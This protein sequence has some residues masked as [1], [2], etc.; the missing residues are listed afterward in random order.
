[1]TV[2]LTFLTR[3]RAEVVRSGAAVER[4][5]RKQWQRTAAALKPGMFRRVDPA[6]FYGGVTPLITKLTRAFVRH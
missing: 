5:R 3:R 1:M 6:V 2:I 4:A